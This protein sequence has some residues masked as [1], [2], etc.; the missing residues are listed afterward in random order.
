M[1]A[2]STR[3]VGISA[4]DEGGLNGSETLSV[5]PFECT[6]DS[7]YYFAAA[8]HEKAVSRF[9]DFFLDG[10]QGFAVLSGDSGLGKTLIRTVLHRRLDS[11]RFVRV[12]IETSLLGFDEMLLE[13]ISQIQGDRVHTADLPDRYSRL[14]LFKTLLSERVIHSGR[15]LL[16]MIDE[17][18]GL[19]RATL[20]DLRN[21]S[22]ISAEKQNLMSV[23]LFGGTQLDNLV[24]GLPEL[25]QRIGE[26]LNLSPLD[27]SETHDYVHHRLRT[28]GSP[29]TLTLADTT[30]AHLH[31]VSGGVPRN[32]NR[33]MKKAL[34]TSM[35]SGH[36]LDDACVLGTLDRFTGPGITQIDHFA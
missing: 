15:H 28:A 26:Q 30:W 36:S 6:R 1:N 10:N 31:R 9:Y 3:V 34:S 13:I 27:S 25:R 21:L 17:A 5:Q 32:I 20:E 23:G 22:N 18:Q 7:Q 2:E 8:S 24:Q 33:I 19:E 4:R 14:A 35:L 16:L 12:S 29:R 11:Q